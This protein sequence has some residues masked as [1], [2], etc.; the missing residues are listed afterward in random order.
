MSAALWGAGIGLAL[1]ATYLAAGMGERAADHAR[2]ERMAAA[3]QGGY[4]DAHG[5]SLQRYGRAARADARALAAQHRADLECLTDA[6]YYEA[7]SESPRGQA[8]VAQVVLNRVKHP[9]FPKSV[10]GVVF[11]GAR[12]AGCQFS[13]ACDGSMRRGREALAW[14]RAHAVAA[15]VLAGAVASSIGAATH[16]HTTAVSPFWAPQMLRV[17]TVGA[18]VFYKFS[19]YRIHAPADEPLVETAVL[20]SSPAAQVPE[21]RVSASMEKA[22]ETSLQP[23][24]PATATAKAAPPPVAPPAKPAEAAM[25]TAPQSVSAGVS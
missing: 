24:S 7:R 10:C 1:G 4:G 19:P 14:D 22:I 9:A 13:F 21:L 8:A 3:A 15:R 12:H 20:I 6:V 16:Y 11:Q 2:A 18:H 17:A 25:L 23:V 5:A